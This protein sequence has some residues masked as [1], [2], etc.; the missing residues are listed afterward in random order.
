[1][2]KLALL[3]SFVIIP[4]FL[5]PAIPLFNVKVLP[6]AVTDTSV[7][8]Y[9]DKPANYSKNEYFEI[10]RNGSVIGKTSKNNYCAG[11]LKAGR[12]YQ[13]QVA[14]KRLQENSKS[15]MVIVTTRPKPEIFNITRLGAKG[16]GKTINT[17][18]IQKAIDACTPNGIVYIPSGT[19]ITGALFVKKN[20]IT[21]YLAKGSVL[22]A[23]DNPDDFPV[24]R[25]RYEGRF[26]DAYSAVINLGSLIG[27]VRYKNI[28]V[29]GQG[30]IDG[31]GDVLAPKQTASRT[32]MARA[33]GLPI[34]NCDSVYLQGF[35]IRN[36]PTWCIH[37]VFTSHLTTDGV[38]VLSEGFGL[39]N[40]DGWDPDSSTDCYLINSILDTHDDYIA[41]KSGADSEGRET[42]K[43]SENIYVSNCYFKRGGGIAIGSEM[44]GGVRNVY[45]TDCYFERADRG[46]HVKSRPGRGGLIENIVFRDIVA[47]R[48]GRWGISVDMWYYVDTY[49]KNQQPREAI[50][51]FKNI[52]F[53]NILIRQV[54]GLP[55]RVNGLPESPITDVVFKN[56]AIGTSDGPARLSYCENILLEDVNA[57]KT[58]WLVNN[59]RNIQVAGNT[60]FN[61]KFDYP[62]TLADSSATYETKAMY[63]N[64]KALSEKGSILFGQQDAT[65]SG[66]GWN[67]NSGRSDIKDI[68][69]KYPAFYSWDYMDFTRP[70]TNN[71]AS[72][73]KI[74]QLTI[75][76]FNR[77]GVNSYC[78]HQWN[79][80]TDGSFYDT[81]VTVKHILPG[82]DRHEK[83]KASLQKIA[84]YAKTLIGRNG[85]LVPVI[86][87]PYHEFDGS[88]FWWGHSHCTTDEFIQLYRYTVTYLRDSLHVR[89]FLY[90]FSPD[91]KFKSEKEYLER[92]PGDS[93]VD[94]LGMDNYWDFRYGGD[95]ADLAHQKLK[96]I[97]DYAQKTGKVAALTET[98]QSMVKDSTWFT[99]RLYKVVKGYPD[100]VRL[101]YIAV[102]RNSVKGFWTPYKGHPAET[103]FIDFCNKKD[104]LLEDELPDMYKMP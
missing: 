36:P 6:G 9:W 10:Y 65:S 31:N 58:I 66:Y 16:D 44:S 42:A 81:T 94:I 49:Q 50:P 8:L 99:Q 29:R 48:F 2:K 4:L 47:E 20:N 64:L 45:F 57:G 30:V 27:G 35:T 56:V 46:F 91:C 76:A 92:Y 73:D 23:S 98:G 25:T 12:T 61:T 78:W 86:F 67:D 103:D 93:Y 83:Y 80:V 59:A 72:M 79:P 55:V 22:K 74:R 71:S 87:R 102:W 1:M 7:T 70:F 14:L 88:W 77:G 101:A 19:Y 37:P 96:I 89:N 62:Y 11:K 17:E 18:F 68:T 28:A 41:I 15:N 40:A 39:S 90:A 52:R 63:A 69:G 54:S 34:I 21:I 104:I 24:L 53:E 33:H 51:V 43:P 97:S 13:F 38:T 75:D 85:V 82:G 60:T 32:R 26:V 84:D 100:T 5:Y 3:F 95:N